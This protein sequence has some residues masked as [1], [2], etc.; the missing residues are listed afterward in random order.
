M[1]RDELEAAIWRNWPTRGPEAG[2]AVDA[3]LAAADAYGL[4]EYGITADRRAAIGAATA[5]RE[6]DQRAGLDVRARRALAAAMHYLD[7][8]TNPA[9]HVRGSA[10][11]S[12][13]PAEV[14]CH[15]CRRTVAWH[16]EA[17]LRAVAR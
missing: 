14:T 2:R 7:Y 11:S 5:T 15:A 3:I 12:S 1:T 8:D 6:R 17:S 4:A 16:N 10:T 13:D 9:C